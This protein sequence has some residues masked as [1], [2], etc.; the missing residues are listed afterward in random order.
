[1]YVP[2]HNK[3]VKKTRISICFGVMYVSGHNKVVK[4]DTYIRPFR[5]NIREFM[6]QTAVDNNISEPMQS[7]RSGHESTCGHITIA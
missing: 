6:K 5:G 7:T 3:L 4:K 1:M 2:G